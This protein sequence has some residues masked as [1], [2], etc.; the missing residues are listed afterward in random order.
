M[1]A[2]PKVIAVCSGKGGVGKTNVATNLAVALAT[3]GLEV[4]LLDADLSLANVDVLLG[5]QPRYNLSHLVAGEVDIDAC[6]LEGPRGIKVVPASSGNFDMTALKSTERASIVQ[7][8]CALPA[9]PEVLLVDTAAGISPAVAQFVSA[10]QRVLVVVCDEPA[11]I[12]DSYALM[13]VFSQH[14]G[15]R[16]FDIVTN[17]S[18]SRRGGARLFEKLSRVA[19]AYLDVVLS[20]AGDVAEDPYLVKAVQQQRAVVDVFPGSPASQGFLALAE[21]A[22]SWPLPA[23]ASGGIEFFLERL[24]LNGSLQA[25]RVA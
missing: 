22:R 23:A 15:V 8:F 16:R 3:Q 4:M 21:R 9:S 14:Y 10:A 19:A 5:L 12:T 2:V 6:L 25:E 24:V 20:H 18:R 11:S 1:N 17:R 7:S 13:K